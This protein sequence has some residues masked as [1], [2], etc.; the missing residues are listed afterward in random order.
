MTISNTRPLSRAEAS[1]YL[2]E[3][4]GISHSPAYLAKLAV[5][6]GGPRFMKARRSVIYT[7][8]L[9]DEYAASIMSPPVSSTSELRAS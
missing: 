3:K 4:H 5:T 6:G 7:A 9:L 1:T 2:K 8:E